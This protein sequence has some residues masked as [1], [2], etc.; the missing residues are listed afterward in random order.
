MEIVANYDGYIVTR[1]ASVESPGLCAYRLISPKD[2]I[3]LTIYKGINDKLEIKFDNEQ[4]VV[5]QLI[6]LNTIPSRTRT[7]EEKYD[8]YGRQIDL[9]FCAQ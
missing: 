2:E 5:I 3:L 1:K 6:E 7:Y 9:G 8:L 4:L